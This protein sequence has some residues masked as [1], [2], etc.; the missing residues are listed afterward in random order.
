[1][2]EPQLLVAS[3]HHTGYLKVAGRFFSTVKCPTHA[4]AYA[5]TMPRSMSLQGAPA[6]A[7]MAHQAGAPGM[8]P[9]CAPGHAGVQSNE[10]L[11]WPVCCHCCLFHSCFALSPPA[12]R[13]A[14]VPEPRTPLRQQKV[15]LNTLTVNTL[16][17]S[18]VTARRQPLRREQGIG[19]SRSG[20]AG[21]FHAWSAGSSRTG[22]RQQTTGCGPPGL[23]C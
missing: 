9:T 18:A 13:H 12:L 2:R 7:W 11:M 23:P 4:H 22:R 5:E 10:A 19:L 6:R 14:A 17:V 3:T 1:M 16:T 8:E 21:V 20:G 15:T